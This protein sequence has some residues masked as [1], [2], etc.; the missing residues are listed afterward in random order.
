MLVPFG[1]G[2][3]FNVMCLTSPPKLIFDSVCVL[4]AVISS[5]VSED[6]ATERNHKAWKFFEG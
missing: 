1:F 3:C 6:S 5:E 4:I 2:G